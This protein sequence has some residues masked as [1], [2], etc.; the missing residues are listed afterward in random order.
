MGKAPGRGKNTG[1]KFTPVNK[2]R[3]SD[4]VG[5]SVRLARNDGGRMADDVLDAGCLY[6]NMQ[7]GRRCWNR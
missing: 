5:Q 6:V 3:M 2:G 7:T 4:A 1:G